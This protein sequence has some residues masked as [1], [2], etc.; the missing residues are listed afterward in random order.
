MYTID[1][2]M[3][4]AETEPVAIS[5][6]AMGA[7]TAGLAL[8]VGFGLPVTVEQSG[9]ILGFVSAMILVVS[10]WQRKKV[11]PMAKLDKVQP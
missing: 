6:A 11:I 9:L 8:A 4:G 1:E 10:L 7:I 2:H 5:G 3:I